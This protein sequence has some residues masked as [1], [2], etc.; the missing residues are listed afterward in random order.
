MKSVVGV[1]AVCLVMISGVSRAALDEV[2]DCN[3]VDRKDIKA[4]AWNVADDWKNFEKHLEE[5]TALN[6][7]K[8]MENRFKKNGKVQCIY[9]EDCGK[10]G[11]KLG[12]ASPLKKKIKM[13]Q[14]FFDNI[15]KMPQAD[16]RACYAGLMT[17]EF[18]HSC[19]RFEK[20][21]EKLED[22]GFS[23]WKGRVNVSNSL[24]AN[25]DCGFD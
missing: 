12:F 24:N 23:Y 16:R 6:I 7:K 3:D 14:T 1:L 18:G 11:C 13:Y 19:D 8:C 9:K 10:K 22:A 21:S 17:H 2:I 4:V 20:G 15:E 5:V 25:L